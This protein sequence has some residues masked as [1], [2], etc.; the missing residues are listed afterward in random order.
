MNE[1]FHKGELA[2]QELAGEAA[3]AQR[4]GRMIGDEIRGA[5]IPFIQRQEVAYL[6]SVDQ[7]GSVWAS[8]L[9]GIAGFA[10]VAHERGLIFD[11][12]LIRSAD[13]DIFYEN[14]EGNPQVGV[15]FLEAEHRRR[16]RVNGRI[17]RSDGRL[18]LNVQEA[19]GNCPK[20]IQAGGIVGSA[21]D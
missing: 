2:V 7:Q 5:A 1:V 9:V 21:P 13:S 4:V 15:L 8:L 18:L 17:Q 12:D 19:F 14:I 3:M 16:Y 10:E 20:Y 6:G 11:E